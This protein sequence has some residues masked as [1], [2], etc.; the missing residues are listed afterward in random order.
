MSNWKKIS[1]AYE[2]NIGSP[3]TKQKPMI[4]E[5]QMP[6]TIEGM[7][8]RMVQMEKRL[9]KLEADHKKLMESK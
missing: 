9:A 8:K 6:L 2:K 1:E 7:A 4:K 5:N 3:K